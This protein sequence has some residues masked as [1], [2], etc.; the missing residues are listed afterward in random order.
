MS[1]FPAIIELSGFNG[2][3]GFKISGALRNEGVG[4]AVGAGDINNDGIPDI[5]IAA[6]GNAGPGPVERSYVL[7]GSA[8]G[9]AANVNVSDLN[10]TDGFKIAGG[11]GEAPGDDIA[12]GDVN[13]DG[14]DDVII[15]S[16]NSSQAFAVFGGQSFGSTFSLPSLT[17][18]NGFQINKADGLTLATGDVNGD[19]FA[20]LIVWSLSGTAWGTDVIFGKASGFPSVIDLTA[21][22]PASGFNFYQREATT[23]VASG[24]F[25]GDGYADI[26]SSSFTDGPLVGGA[27]PS[28]QG[29]VD[30][31]FGRPSGLGNLTASDLNGSNGFQ[32]HGVTYERLGLHVAN[33]GDIN[34]D[35]IDD[36]MILDDP[37]IAERAAYVVFGSRSGFPA[38]FDLSTLNGA[39]GFKIDATLA[40]SIAG[41]GDVN[42]DGFGDI[43][44]GEPS[45]NAHGPASG[46]SYV[47]FGKAS[48][49]GATID[50]STLNGI[51]G[52]KIKGVTAQDASGTSVASAG[53][54]NGDG[55][56]DLLIG[57]PGADQNAN[58]AGA[59]YVVYSVLPTTSVTRVGTDAS[60]NLVGGNLDDVLRGQGGNDHLFGHD[61]NDLLDGGPGNDILDGGPGTDT[62]T[63]AAALSGVTVSLAVTA[64]QATGGAGTDTLIAVENLIGSKYADILTGDGADNVLTG[65]GGVDTLVGGGGA[66]RLIGGAAHDNLTG[67]SGNDVFVFTSLTDSTLNAPDT[68]TDFVSGQDKIDLSAIDANAATTGDQ[69]FHLGATAGHAGDI[70]VSY[71]AVHHRTVLDLY[72]DSDTNAD[73][74]IWLAGN[75][76]GLTAGD[77]VI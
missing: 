28:E 46:E 17:G 4:H 26:V 64:P 44:I 73:A 56:A 35:G 45:A 52:F 23:D 6:E 1:Q 34:G 33:A 19:G 60:Q 68:I 54:L 40:L 15:A 49:F 14:H 20:D 27:V 13:G 2:S 12:A 16:D 57:A 59:T 67:G 51:T 41:A 32:I 74:R 5:L 3:N 31:I 24:D 36:L 30:V 9:F 61:G 70:V 11:V 71:D 77:F 25:N 22:P 21:P 75:H 47:I 50:P 37:E 42:G 29:A 53:D 38:T 7:Y 55:L 48:G 72:I 69:A 18:A 63:Y 62:A 43:V 76:A 10:G 8:T 66:D 58:N 39:N 65:G